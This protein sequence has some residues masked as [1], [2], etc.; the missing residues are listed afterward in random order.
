[1]NQ[2]PESQEPVQ[3]T[4]WRCFSGSA[5]ASAIAYCAYLL[6]S[7]ISQS[8]A[9]KPIHSDNQTVITIAGAVRTLVVGISTLGTFVFAFAALGLFA[10]GI[11]ILIQRFTSQPTPPNS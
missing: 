7:S 3:P 8:F 1:M 6:T 9:N 10:L 11:Q 5:V 2:Q 4:I